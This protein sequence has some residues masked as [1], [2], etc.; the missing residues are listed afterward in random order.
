M[1]LSAHALAS[2]QPDLGAVRNDW[3]PASWLATIKINA[4]AT[5]DPEEIVRSSMPERRFS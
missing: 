3:L 2:E 5:R 4:L 1:T